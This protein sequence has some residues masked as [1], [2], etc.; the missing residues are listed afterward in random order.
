[1][2]KF[3]ICEILVALDHVQSNGFVYRDLKPENIILDEV[4]HCKLVDF[5]FT[6]R[7]DPDGRMRTLCGKL[8]HIKSCPLL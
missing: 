2:A 8:Y 4:G 6:V 5:G 1:M 3:Y 7:P